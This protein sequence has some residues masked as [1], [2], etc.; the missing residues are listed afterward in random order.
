M[1]IEINV[2]YLYPG[3]AIIIFV[4]G[5]LIYLNINNNSGITS[6]SAMELKFEE[7]SNEN[8]NI[9]GGSGYIYDMDDDARLQGSCCSPME[10]HR[11]KEQVEGLNTLREKYSYLNNDLRF[12]PDDPYDIPVSLAKELL[13]YQKTIQLTPEQQAVYDEA[14]K[15]SH[16][17]GPC[18]CKCWRWYAFEGQAKKLITDYGF[19]SEQIAELWDIEDGCGGSGHAGHEGVTERETFEPQI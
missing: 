18:C 3:I 12:I 19:N 9:C 11:Y 5:L 16:E 8:T 4:I 14:M 6:A 10:F 2:K 15:M 7:L 17:G 13:E 1:K